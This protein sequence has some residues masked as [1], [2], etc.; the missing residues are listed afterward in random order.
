MLYVIQTGGNFVEQATP[1]EDIIYLK[2]SLIS[3]VNSNTEY[4]YSDGH[5][6]DK[7]TTFYDSTMI[8]DLPTIIDWNSINAS[9]WGDD[10]NL[11]IKRKKQAEFLVSDDVPEECIILFGC[12]N[13]KAKD[14]LLS[15][16]IDEQKIKI[17][18]SAY[19]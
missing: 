15:M 14:K 9:F 10:D 8:N 17:G 5:A 3:I 2:C 7:Y 11:N 12:Y 6:T 16:G 4:Y 13:E 19:Y 1:P 18:P